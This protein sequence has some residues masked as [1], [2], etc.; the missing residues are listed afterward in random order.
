MFEI[1]SLYQIGIMR[2]EWLENEKENAKFQF[3]K[4]VSQNKFF[5]MIL[6]FFKIKN[7][8]LFS[9]LKNSLSIFFKLKLDFWRIWYLREDFLRVNL[10]VFTYLFEPF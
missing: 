10:D 3:K 5:K 2:L 7:K 6:S 4:Y 8:K 1:S 9:N